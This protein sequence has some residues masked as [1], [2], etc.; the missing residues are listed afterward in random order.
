MCNRYI[1]VTGGGRGVFSICEEVVDIAKWLTLRKSVFVNNVADWNL[2]TPEGKD[3]I[4][5]KHQNPITN[6]CSVIF[7]KDGILTYTTART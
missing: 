5:S 2:L 4:A 6:Q 7:Q 1:E 3:T